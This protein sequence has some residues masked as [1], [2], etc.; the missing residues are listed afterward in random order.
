MSEE[1]EGILRKSLDDVCRA[2]KRQTFVFIIL[3][4]TVIVCILFL[5]RVSENPATDV[6]R[7]LFLSVG[8]LL[9]MMVYVA[10]AVAMVITSMTT[11]VL[12]AI[13]LVSK[14]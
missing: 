5:G 3:F 9:F 13:E 8:A 1:P 14:T 2:K 12:K 11:R 7:M 6:R 4:V 10:M